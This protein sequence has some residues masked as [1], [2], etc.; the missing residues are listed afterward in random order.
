MG[1]S[2][3]AVK[4]GNVDRMVQAILKKTEKPTEF[5]NL[6]ELSYSPCF[7]CA[8]L[9]AGDNLCE[10][11]DDLKPLLPK[12]LSSEAIVL[13]TPTY[14]G[15]MNGFM[16]VFLE[17]F[18]C[19]RHQKY[20]LEER[21]YVVVAA[22]CD[23]GDAESSIDSVRSRMGHICAD[24]TGSVFFH[25]GN[26]PCYC[27]GYGTKCTVGG[28]FRQHGEEGQQRAKK[29]IQFIKQWEDDRE[30]VA[31]IDRLADRLGTAIQQAGMHPDARVNEPVE[32]GKT[33]RG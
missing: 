26:F 19:L 15:R 31:Q 33:L 12:I 32:Y 29:G 1:F 30:T 24:L 17:R 22:G 25:S 27:C 20:P 28:L 2:S 21:P 8:H 4:G 16:A 7:G 9:C 3:S 23:S 10:L 14:F 11:E 6:T 18:W 5:I 13:G